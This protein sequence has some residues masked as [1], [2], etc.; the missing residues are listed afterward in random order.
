MTEGSGCLPKSFLKFLNPDGGLPYTP[1]APSF[2]EPTLLMILAFVAAGDPANAQPLVDWVLKIRN[3]NGSI[4]L[5]R[6]FPAEGLWNTP[7]LAIVMHHMEHKTERDAAIDFVLQFRSVRL[8]RSPENDVNTLLVG[9]PWV[10]QT[11]GWVEPTSWALLALE[12]AGMSDSP[13]AIEG[14]RLLVDRCLPEGGWN[15]GNKT[16]FNTVLLPFWEATALAQMAIGDHSK[17]L[18]DRNLNL[19]ERAL[20]EMHSLMTN[21]MAC[22]CLNR[23]G[24]K[25]EAVRSRIRSMLTDE[26]REDLNLANS[27]LGLIAL[28]G[29][30]V[31]TR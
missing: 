19:L 22:L 10:P 3:P 8:Q 31:L 25:T 5:N 17:D 18:T 20:P 28:S 30:R 15:Y 27:A 23:F 11:F 16:M 21:A 12:L 2:S 7:L 1:G 9:W 29:K 26:N 13:R 24:R 14:R 6:E 4:G